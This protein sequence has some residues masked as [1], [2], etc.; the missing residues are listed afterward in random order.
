MGGHG[1]AERLCG[2]SV[3]EAKL[4][5]H[6]DELRAQEVSSQAEGDA[7]GQQAHPAPPQG[8]GLLHHAEGLLHVCAAEAPACACA[9][10]MD[11]VQVREEQGV[12][13]AFQQLRGMAVDQLHRV[14]CLVQRVF[15]GQGHGAFGAWLREPQRAAEF[16][17]E[18]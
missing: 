13:A 10:M 3:L 11:A 5:A 9:G 6:G 17:E 14:A 2:A 16:L 18:A 4:S 15:L 1:R 12:D 7:R 8:H